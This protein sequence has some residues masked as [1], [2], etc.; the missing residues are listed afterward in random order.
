MDNRLYPLAALT[1]IQD[2]L[3][4]PNGCAKFNRVNNYGGFHLSC[5]QLQKGADKPLKRLIVLLK[6]RVEQVIIGHS[7]RDRPFGHTQE[8]RTS[9]RAV[10]VS[11]P[12]AAG[13]E[14]PYRWHGTAQM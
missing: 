9:Y 12:P 6:K 7:D 5:I 2:K 10:A 8:I 11:S 14:P 3:L 4:V 13:A 1:G